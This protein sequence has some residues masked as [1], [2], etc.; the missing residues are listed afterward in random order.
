MP[1]AGIKTGDG[2]DAAAEE[3]FEGPEVAEQVMDMF[4]AGEIGEQAEGTEVDDEVLEELDMGDEP[5][6]KVAKSKVQAKP[7][8]KAE[9]TPEVSEEQDEEAEAELEAEDEVV[10]PESQRI[11]D[12]QAEVLAMKAL[13][14][15]PNAQVPMQSQTPVAP[16]AP[17][18]A[19][20]VPFAGAVPQ[21]QAPSE[22]EFAE[23]LSDPGKFTEFF[24]KGLAQY[25]QQTMVDLAPVVT[26]QIQTNDTIK[27]FF[28]KEENK[29][30][31]SGHVRQLVI[32]YAGQLEAQGQATGSI[33]DTLEKAVDLVRTQLKI[34]QSKGPVRIGRKNL[35]A[36]VVP[37]VAK[38]RKFAGGNQT[39]KP[40]KGAEE[41]EDEVGDMISDMARVGGRQ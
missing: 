28:G 31:T 2:R 12:L 29:D 6:E 38:P 32:Q 36:A 3:Q 9:W 15:D 8:V 4:S 37:N 33:T 14:G 34:V 17:V 41:P 20:P 19:A 23:I 1:K 35:Q 16:V 5:E 30:V 26:T 40:V 10:S 24:V 21:L 11:I 22:E 13:M 39:R 25:K 7:K 27:A 18:A